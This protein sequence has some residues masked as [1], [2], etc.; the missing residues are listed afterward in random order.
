MAKS[1]SDIKELEKELE[2]YKNILDNLPVGLHVQDGSGKPIISNKQYDKFNSMSNGLFQINRIGTDNK[3][4]ALAITCTNVFD[5]ANLYA[6]NLPK[7]KPNQGN[8]EINGVLEHL[9]FIHLETIST[10]LNILHF[11]KGAEQLFGFNAESVTGYSIKK[12]VDYDYF[13]KIMSIVKSIKSLGDNYSGETEFKKKNG[14]VFQGV[15]EWYPIFD[16]KQKLESCLVVILDITNR[17]VAEAD[18]RNSELKFRSLFENSIDPMLLL[19]GYNIK[20]CNYAALKLFE[21]TD[22]KQIIGRKPSDL[23]PEFQ[24]DGDSS[25]MK[26]LR[27]VEGAAQKGATRFIWEH[28]N[29]KGEIIPTEVSL[30]VLYIENRR[31]VYAIIRDIRDRIDADRKIRESEE[32]VR[33]LTNQLPVGIYRT[34][35]EGKLFYANPALLEIL[36]FEK[37]IDLKE[38]NV[39]DLYVNPHKRELHLNELSKR[40]SVVISEYELINSKNQKIIIRD[41]GSPIKNA[42]GELD[43]IDGIMEDITERKRAENALQTI[44]EGTARNT[45]VNFFSSFVYYLAEVFDVSDTCIYIVG[46]NKKPGYVLA[47]WGD[48]QFYETFEIDIHLHEKFLPSVF[49]HQ[50]DSPFL[51]IPRAKG[52]SYVKYILGIPIFENGKKLKGFVLAMDK[53]KPEPKKRNEFIL[54]IFATRAA[55]EIERKN[56]EDYLKNAKEQAEAANKAKSLFLANM[57]HEIR[58]PMNGIIGMT[59]LVLKSELTPEQRIH[60]NLVKTSADSLLNIIN[61]ILDL[62]K[63]ESG[64]LLLDSL[65]FELNSTIEKSVDMFALKAYRKSIELTCF[66]EP[67]LPIYLIGDPTRLRQVLI[68][69]I[70]NAVKFTST[71]EI[72]IKVSKENSIDE[73]HIQIKFSVE[74]TGIGISEDNLQRIFDDFAQADAST[75]REYGGTGLGL[76]ISKHLVEKM[77]GYIS[78]SSTEGAGSKFLFSLP[79]EIQMANNKRYR[80][81]LEKKSENLKNLKTLV[82]DDNSTNLLILENMLEFYGLDT[83]TTNDPMDA[84]DLYH[85]ENAKGKPYELLILDYMM[86]GLDGVT[87]AKKLKNIAYA[88]IILLSSSNGFEELNPK[89]REVLDAYLVKPVK[90]SQLLNTIEKALGVESY[91]EVGDKTYKS[92][93]SYNTPE[94]FIMPENLNILLAEDNMVNQILITDLC[95]VN[96]WGITTVENGRD[97][98]EECRKGIYDIILMDIQMP[99][100]D[101]IE[102]TELIRNDKEYSQIP[103]IALTA[104]ALK[105]DREKFLAAGM[106]DYI[107]KPVSDKLLFAAIENQI[108]LKKKT[109]DKREF[110]PADFTNLLKVLK[111]NSKIIIIMVESFFEE[112]PSLVQEMEEGIKAENYKKL[113]YAAHKLKGALVNFD[114][115]EA[116]SLALDLE[117]MGKNEKLANADE[118]LNKLSYE[119]NRFREYFKKIKW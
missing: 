40:E 48:R 111:G 11:S 67:D 37:N 110:P 106:D 87:L 104:H 3:G 12:L 53:E 23:S 105:G 118:T 108:R 93:L 74:D 55:A 61:D 80:E 35:P 117:L 103:I 21:T 112:L 36:G 68:N 4:E 79:F 27:M 10:D 113:D 71:G 94:E 16:A 49:Y 77:G 64:K 88:K 9:A 51:N 63:I 72:K 97:A 34:N 98:V 38:I 96:G 32:R 95:E 107:S 22:K 52:N 92:E 78:V 101:G 69:I 82:V 25:Y 47:Y 84:I 8:V 115:K 2:L 24:S 58:T 13:D 116:A 57:S 20:D 41:T 7:S 56:M 62:S 91:E 29:L 66:I 39:T 100:M 5:V 15:Y 83:T 76:A 33:T 6:E 44:V 85:S 45:G 1:H 42:D 50:E 18:I 109:K 31:N 99:E 81:N 19:D 30:A 73:N 54:E 28:K 114:A 119:M 102:A 89:E 59:D 26:M 43:Y 14:L 46:D 70:S 86:P 90:Q 60:L 65:E 17:I 75:T